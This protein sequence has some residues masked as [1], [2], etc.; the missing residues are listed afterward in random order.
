MENKIKKELTDVE[1]RRLCPGIPITEYSNLPMTD[2]SSALGD[3]GCGFLF[4]VEQNTPSVSTG[5]WLGMLRKDS[6]IEFFDPYGAKRGGDPWFLDHTFVTPETLNKLKE[7]SPIVKQW[8]LKNNLRPSYNPYHYQQMKNGINTCGRHCCARI[9]N[10]QMSEDEYHNY[11]MSLCN[12]YNASP[13]VIV[14]MI[15]REV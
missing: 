3:N 15:T 8:A 5:H 10:A 7:S 14:T 11:I 13:D 1:V 9:M 2:A 6:N 4:F 12:K